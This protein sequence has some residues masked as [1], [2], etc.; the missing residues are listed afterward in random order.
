MRKSAWYMTFLS[1]AALAATV[2]CGDSGVEPC[3][4]ASGLICPPEDGGVTDADVPTDTGSMADRPD[5]GTSTCG[6]VGRTGGLCRMGSCFM[7]L[8]CFEEFTDMGA[9]LT[10]RAAF[11]IDQAVEDPANPGTFLPVETP[12][13]ANDVP[14]TFTSDTLCSEPCNTSL[15]PASDTCGACASCSDQVGNDLGF[16][17]LPFLQDAQRLFGTDTGLCRPHC[18]FDAEGRGR[19]CPAGYSCDPFSNLC[20]EACVTDANCQSAIIITE[21]GEL[22]TVQFPDSGRTCNMTTGRCD[23]TG[24]ETAQVGDACESATDCLSDIGIC[25]NGGTCGET[26]C[27]TASDTMSDFSCDGGRGIC[28]GT[29]GNGSVCVEGCNTAAD[30]NPGN[31]CQALG[32]TQMPGGFSGYCLPGCNATTACRA[33]ERCDIPEGETAGSCEAPCD[34]AATVSECETN[35]V[36]EA[37]AGSTPAYGFCRPVDG[38]CFDS[39]ACFNGQICNNETGASSYGRCVDPCTADTDCTVGDATTCVT[40]TANPLAGLCVETCTAAADC[41]PAGVTTRT[42]R[43]P[44]GSTDGYCVEAPAA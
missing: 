16:G 29:T 24:D 20:F 10:Y 11:N 31:A 13:P 40:D 30:C 1:A 7:G 12:V 34:P 4:P 21:E 42:C 17:V 26:Q 28:L 36:C 39:T 18:V 15:P 5:T 43:V 38:I 35:E 44:V 23:W 33:E 6:D 22:G 8:T 2:G 25:L 3:D 9:Q 14:L 19:G 32:G 27:A 41:N 37:V